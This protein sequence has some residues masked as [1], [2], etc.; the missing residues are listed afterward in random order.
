MRILNKIIEY[1]LYLLV[2]LLPWQTRWIIKAGELNGGY[3][4]YGTISLYIVDVLLISILLLFTLSFFGKEVKSEK[5]K[6]KSYW[7]IIAGFEL[8]VF[9]SMFFAPDKMVAIYSYIKLLLGIGLFWM[10][11][12]ASYSKVKL[13][14]SLLVGIVIQGGVGVYQF[15]TQ[16][17]FASKWLGMARHL[18]SDLGTSVV[19]TVEGERW[20][21]AYGGLDHPNMLGGVIVVGILLLVAIYLKYYKD[22]NIESKAQIAFYALFLIFVSALFFS[23]SRGAWL[24]LVA[25]VAI[26][27]FLSFIQKDYIRQKM[28]FKIIVVASVLV[29]I[30]SSLYSDLISTRLSTDTRLEI[31]SNVERIE[32]YQDARRLISEHWLVGVGIGNY[33]LAV[34]QE[35]IEDQESYF[36]QPTHNTFLLIL[37]EVGIIG[38]VFFLA[39]L[40]YLVWAGLKNRKNNIFILPILF[41]IV[42]MMMVDHWW[43]SLHFGILLFWLLSGLM[44]RSIESE[45]KIL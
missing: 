17:A 26:M 42:I 24:G 44:I 9:V 40:G 2:F 34:R 30:F 20:L 31:K 27:L 23:F 11:V 28:L 4:E 18:S 29:F 10:I 5:L 41:S 21:R 12:S 16:S 1:G 38:L 43:W 32:S 37:A 3:Y 6:V 7:W 8:I 25:G 14:G 15:I 35:L 19:Q 39:F 36:Y 13:L 22:K 33:T 45:K